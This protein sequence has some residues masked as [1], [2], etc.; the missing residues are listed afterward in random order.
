MKINNSSMLL[1]AVTDR[2]WL[3]GQT[4]ENQVEVAVSNGVTF[5]QLREKDLNLDDFTDLAKK[6]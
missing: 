3:G 4:L 5:I 6:I 2:T 1:Y